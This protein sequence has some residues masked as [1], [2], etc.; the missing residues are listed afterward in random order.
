MTMTGDTDECMPQKDDSRSS[1]P[2]CGM[3]EDGEDEASLR[4]ILNELRDFRRDN[5]HQLTEIKQELHKTNDRLVEAETRIDEAET[6]L[7]AMSTLVKRLSQRQANMEAKLIDQEGR[8]RRD[9]IRI[10][11]IPEDAEGDNVSLFLEN[12]L[13]ESLGFPPG[14]E[15]KIERAHR[16]P[17]PKPTDPQMKPRSI[18]A[19]LA[20]YK[21]KEEVIRKAWQK[22]EVFYNNTRFYVDHDYPS[23]ILKRRVEYAEAKKIL[24]ER[25]IKFQTP[26]PARLR[27]F[28]NDGT[29]LYQSATEAT[30]D[31]ASRGFPVTIIPAPDNPDQRET[32]LL[33][34]WQVIG[35]RRAGTTSTSD[36]APQKKKAPQ[37]QFKEKLQEFRRNPPPE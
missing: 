7:Q 36:R 6:A 32:E 3:S 25:K 1:S 30:E 8:A 4:G 2:T 10:Y 9:N 5:K 11:G 24:K 21:V 15:L 27:V 37:T 14:T 29:R 23:V 19:K 33:S 13:K 28:Y 20:S 12:L 16:A 31:M 35:R 17:V 34:T 18:I 26:Y 22:R